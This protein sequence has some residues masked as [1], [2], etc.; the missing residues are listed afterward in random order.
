[1][2][3]K[4]KK[5]KYI[6]SVINDWFFNY[7]DAEFNNNK[8]EWYPYNISERISNYVLLC[9]L[10]IIKNNKSNM[11]HL[12]SQMYFL[13]QNI[14]FYKDKKSNHTL[15][16]ARAIFLLSCLSKNKIFKIFSIYILLKSIVSNSFN[17]CKNITNSISFD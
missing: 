11:N 7:Q 16:N 4:N 10:K 2:K 9:E 3:K 12:T 13:S 1:M 14:E 8:I 17:I 5:K 15:N 6:S